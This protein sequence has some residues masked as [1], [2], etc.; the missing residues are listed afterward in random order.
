[1]VARLTPDQTV[2]G[3]TPAAATFAVICV[4]VSGVG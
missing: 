3:S 2:V 1:M 4:L